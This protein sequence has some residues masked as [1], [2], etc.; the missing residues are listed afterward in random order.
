MN[1]TEYSRQWRKGHKEQGLCTRCNNKAIANSV[2]CLFHL[3]KRRVYDRRYRQ[4][5]RELLT[6]KSRE[7]SAIYLLEGRCYRCGAPLLEDEINY[8]LA[9]R[10]GRKQPIIKGVLV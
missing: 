9:C 7:L 10:A 4:K 5:N 8:C 3:D 2:L 1:S 6:Q